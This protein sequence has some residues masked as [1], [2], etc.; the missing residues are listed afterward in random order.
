MIIQAILILLPMSQLLEYI[1]LNVCGN[2]TNH[3]KPSKLVL[4]YED[5]RQ[6]NII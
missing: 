1:L 6:Q 4:I 2:E 5:S 3:T